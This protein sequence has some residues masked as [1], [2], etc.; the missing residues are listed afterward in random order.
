MPCRMP[1]ACSATGP[2]AFAMIIGV[3]PLPL[4]SVPMMST[5]KSRI[6]RV[7]STT[8]YAVP[9]MPG[10]ISAVRHVAG[11][12]SAVISRLPQRSAATAAAAFFIYLCKKFTPS[13]CGHFSYARC[14][15]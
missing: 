10:V 11:I 2:D 1:P 9:D 13:D 12:A 14:P 15:S 8:V 6:S 3:D 5:W 7:A 4:S